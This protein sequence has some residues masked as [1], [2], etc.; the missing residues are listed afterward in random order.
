MAKINARGAYKLAEVTAEHKG[1][2]YDKRPTV[3]RYVFV[4]RSDGTVLKRHVSTQRDGEEKDTRTSSTYSVFGK[5]GKASAELGTF[6]ARDRLAA[7]LTGRGYTVID[8]DTLR[9][10]QAAARLYDACTGSGKSV[11]SVNKTSVDLGSKFGGQI[12]STCP[13]CQRRVKPVRNR[14]TR[15]EWCLPRHKPREH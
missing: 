5:L 13:D 14:Y 9:S 7:A 1:V 4:Y 3:W 10:E 11:T 8:D 15:G 6:G 12:Y 2:D